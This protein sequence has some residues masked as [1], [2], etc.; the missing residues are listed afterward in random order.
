MPPFSLIFFGHSKP[1]HYLTVTTILASCCVTEVLAQ[2]EGGPNRE[3]TQWSI[4]VAGI[5]TQKPYKDIDLDAIAFPFVTVENKYLRW[6]GPTLDIKL[7]GLESGEHQLNFNISLEYDMGGYS[8]KEAE[9]TPILNGME[10]RDTGIWA[11]AKMEWRNPLV[12]VNVEWMT[13]ASGNSD[14]QRYAIGLEKTWMLGQHLMLTPHIKAVSLN[15]KYVDYYYGVRSSEVREDRSLYIGE[16]TINVNYGL[17]AAYLINEKHSV[18]IDLGV[19]TLGNEIK[20]SP[21]VDDSKETNAFLVY[22]YSF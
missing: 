3:G 1:I 11:G 15:D 4:G 12:D 9:K 2:G 14:G 20:T 7:P 22:M 5:A 19:T 6:F 21:L 8:E 10:L 16:S 13:D 18:F 17:R